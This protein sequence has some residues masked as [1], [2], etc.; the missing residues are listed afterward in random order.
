[1]KVCPLCY[2][3][4]VVP[5]INVKG[6]TISRCFNCGVLYTV[7]EDKRVKERNNFYRD[8]YVNAY[9]SRK[10]Q[11]K[12]R[13][14]EH[15]FRIEKYKRGGELLD[16][17][18]GIGYFIEIAEQSGNYSWKTRGLE[19]NK[20]LILRT[21][22][23]IRLKVVHGSIAKLPFKK[24]SFDCITCF[25]VLEH[26]LG[27][28]SNLS[29]IIKILKKDGVIVIQAPNYKSLMAYWTGEKWDWW[30]P[31]DHVLHFSFKFL[32]TLLKENNFEI[33]EAYTYEPTKDFL[34]NVK[35]KCGQSLIIKLLFYLIVPLLVI[36][37]RISWLFNYGALS[38]V[39]AKKK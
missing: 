10:K 26:D 2:S 21:K 33:L 13:F 28:K 20:H 16:L 37:E 24:S 11:L 30:A 15:L 8:E 1:M 5:Y 35:A 25:D 34:L 3:E 6:W 29:E 4:R 36:L 14:K 31:P 38:F 27:L 17:G 9:I 7:V 18:C 23:E 19:L 22:S 12:N 39:I 32:L